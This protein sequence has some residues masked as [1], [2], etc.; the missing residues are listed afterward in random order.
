MCLG[1]MDCAFLKKSFYVS[2]IFPW[3]VSNHYFSLGKKNGKKVEKR[4]DA[5][6]LHCISCKIWC[7]LD[8]KM[9]QLESLKSILKGEADCSYST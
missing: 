6:L 1:V 5:T 9:S 4:K 3:I 7:L 8:T 2:K